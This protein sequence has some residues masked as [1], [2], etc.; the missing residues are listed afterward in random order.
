M[1]TNEE[2][3]SKKYLDHLKAID[4]AEGIYKVAPNQYT[5]QKVDELKSKVFSAQERF[6]PEYIREYQKTKKDSKIEAENEIAHLL[7]SLHIEDLFESGK[8]SHDKRVDLHEKNN[9]KYNKTYL[10]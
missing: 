10:R 8:I 2:V 3:F 9:Q 1:I 5:K 7:N 4:I 6:T